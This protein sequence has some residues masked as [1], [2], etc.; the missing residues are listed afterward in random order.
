VIVN[1]IKIVVTIIISI[2]TIIGKVSN[3]AESDAEGSPVELVG[4]WL[5][6]G[7]TLMHSLLMV[8]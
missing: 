1:T 4:N 6:K 2:I 5:M 7:Q 8:G 3:P